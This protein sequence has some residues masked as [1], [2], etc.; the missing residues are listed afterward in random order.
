MSNNTC[1]VGTAT[2]V[3]MALATMLSPDRAFAEEDTLPDHPMMSDRFFVGAGVVWA[4]SNVT[5]NLNTGRVGLGKFL[6][7]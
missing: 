7:L 4:E 5:A 6:F 2:I 1:A 3:A